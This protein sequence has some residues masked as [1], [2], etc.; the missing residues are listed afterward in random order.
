MEYEFE[1]RRNERSFQAEFGGGTGHTNYGLRP[2]HQLAGGDIT[3]GVADGHAVGSQNTDGRNY[4]IRADE[5]ALGESAADTRSG[6]REVIG[7]TKSNVGNHDVRG[8]E[9]GSGGEEPRLTGWEAER[10]DLIAAEML[11]R[12]EQK[13]QLQTAPTGGVYRATAPDIVGGIA[14]LATIVEDEPADDT[15]YTREHVDRK[16]LAKELRKKEELGM[17]MG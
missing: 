17:H 16:A 11:R 2:R 10:A 1:I 5:M 7:D 14:A 13:S 9:A 6:H 15:E 4:D 8:V 3:A 12:A